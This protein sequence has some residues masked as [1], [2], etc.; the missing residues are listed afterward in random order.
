MSL[1]ADRRD[2]QKSVARKQEGIVGTVSLQA[3]RRGGQK[4]VARKQ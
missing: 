2:G 4:G 1:Q 3:D